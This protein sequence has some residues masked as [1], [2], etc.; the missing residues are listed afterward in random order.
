MAH[1][2]TLKGPRPSHRG[3]GRGQVLIILAVGIL[4][5]GPLCGWSAVGHRV[6]AQLAWEQLDPATRDRLDAILQQM[7]ADAGLAEMSVGADPAERPRKRFL[8][9]SVWSDV[10]RDEAFP[11]RRQ[12][13]HRG[14]WHYI[15]H[16]WDQPADGPARLRRDRQPP[17]ENIVSSLATLRSTLAD[18]SAPAAERA[19]AL[20]WILHLVGDI[21]QP[22]HTT[23]RITAT[24]PEG[25]RGGNLFQLRKR[26][27]LHR[28]WDG[29]LRLEY[30]RAAIE[31]IADEIG[32]KHPRPSLA[33]DLAEGQPSSWAEEGLAITME[34]VYPADLKRGQKPNRAYR[35]QAIETAER[36]IAIAGQ[37]LADYL[38]TTLDSGTTKPNRE[39]RRSGQ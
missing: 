7:P 9:A 27:N 33:E 19:V 29:I 23:A 12:R 25:D 38:A 28:Y 24:E 21:H 31:E 3:A 8:D 1:R 32:A 15:N 13:Y 11:D 17:D 10:V 35:R 4:C 26:N 14:R 20:A 36:R 2:G 18:E 34:Q 6:V 16:F 37:R 5:C 22:L 39:I 30:P